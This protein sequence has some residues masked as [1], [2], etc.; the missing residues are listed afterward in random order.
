VVGGQRREAGDRLADP[1]GAAAAAGGRE[2]R[3][4]AVV[5]SRAV[6][7]DVVGGLAPR[8]D[9]AV[10]RC[11]GVG[12]GGGGER[13]RCGCGGGLGVR[14]A[15]G[16]D[17]GGQGEGDRDARAACRAAKARR[18]DRGCYLRAA[19]RGHVRKPTPAVPWGNRAA[20]WHE[21][22]RPRSVINRHRSLVSDFHTSPPI[23]PRPRGPTADAEVRV[24]IHKAAS[25]C[26]S[27]FRQASRPEPRA[28]T[29]NDCW[30]RNESLHINPMVGPAFVGL[31]F[32]RWP[33]SDDGCP[34]AFL[35]MKPCAAG[36]DGV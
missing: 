28:Q 18:S 16:V 7:E 14:R 1:D 8:V 11:R 29:W 13:I 3:V 25:V 35:Q 9:G 20:A 4:G 36:E 27:E 10:E 15:G 6:L 2:R 22:F 21:G 19:G 23:D 12:D 30:S 32:S 34:H 31:R 33:A 17:A 24:R 26:L 5:A